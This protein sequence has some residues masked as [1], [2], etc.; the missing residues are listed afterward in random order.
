MPNTIMEEHQEHRQGRIYDNMSSLKTKF[1]CH[2]QWNLQC[3]GNNVC[4]LLTMA[5]NQNLK[6]LWPDSEEL[7]IYLKK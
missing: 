7:Q 2:D 6:F 3:K 5:S 4:I 1:I